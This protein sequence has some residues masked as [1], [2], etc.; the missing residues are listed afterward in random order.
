MS[1][2]YKWKCLTAKSTT[3]MSDL[4]PQRRRIQWF[5]PFCNFRAVTSR[6]DLPTRGGG[7]VLLSSHLSQ[8]K[9]GRCTLQTFCSTETKPGWAAWNILMSLSYVSWSFIVSLVGCFTGT[10]FPHRWDVVK[11]SFSFF[12]PYLFI[13]YFLSQQ[14]YFNFWLEAVSKQTNKK[15]TTTTKKTTGF[16]EEM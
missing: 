13:Y 12:S 10:C 16:Q 8:Q 1:V 4:F 7:R 11:D 6:E 15:R 3:L 5:A 14:V 9:F 2:F